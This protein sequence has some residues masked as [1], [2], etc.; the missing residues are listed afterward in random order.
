MINM[1]K[2]IIQAQFSGFLIEESGLL[3]YLFERNVGVS[4]MF[5]TIYSL[6][7]S[8][9]FITSYTFLSFFLYEKS[10]KRFSYAHEN[11]NH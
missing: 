6:F 1:F 9:L 3:K 8:T 5:A 2:T 7:D 4:V 10:N 11:K